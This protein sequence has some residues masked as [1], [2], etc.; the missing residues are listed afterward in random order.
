ML[1]GCFLIGSMGFFCGLEGMTQGCLLTVNPNVR[2]K[3]VS[4]G[5]TNT[6]KAQFIVFV[7][8]AIALILMMS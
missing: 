3:L 1:L 8:C 6:F 4:V 2:S 7:T 5:T